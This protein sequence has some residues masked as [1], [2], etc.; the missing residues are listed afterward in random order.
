MAKRFQYRVCYSVM[1]RVTFSNGVWLGADIPEAQRK[2]QDVETCP[3]I[4][5]HLQQLGEEGWELVTIL[6]TPAARPQG[7][8]VRTLYLKREL[9]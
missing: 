9:S 2:Q 4:W 6:E 7:L 3:Q 1:D 5:D 8:P